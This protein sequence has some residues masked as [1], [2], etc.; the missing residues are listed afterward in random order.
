MEGWEAGWR[1]TTRM[2]MSVGGLRGESGSVLDVHA[3]DGCTW[4]RHCLWASLRD[5]G[6]G[7]MCVYEGWVH[8]Y[9][10]GGWV[11]V[12]F[13][14]DCYCK[15]DKRDLIQPWGTPGGGGTGD[16]LRCVD[17]GRP[18]VGPVVLLLQLNQKPLTHNVHSNEGEKCLQNNI[19]YTLHFF[20]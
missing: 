4:F 12:S 20:F 14:Y 16:T 13:G 5:V 6:V 1:K 11:D 9:R 19:K 2:G 3:L 18:R 8:S 15:G 17:Q 10:T 7:C